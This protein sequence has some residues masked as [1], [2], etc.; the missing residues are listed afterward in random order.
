MANTA[1]HLFALA[2]LI[3]ETCLVFVVAIV[4]TRAIGGRRREAVQLAITALAPLVVWR[5]YLGF[6]LYPGSGVRAFW[7]DPEAVGRPFGG[8]ARLWTDLARGTYMPAFT[9]LAGAA[10]CYSVVLIGAL[11]LAGTAVVTYPNAAAIAAFVYALIAIS[12]TYG[13]VW[14]HVGNAQRAS[15]ELFVI[16]AI[17]Y[18]TTPADARW[19]RLAFGAFWISTAVYAWFLA[20][21]ADSIRRAMLPAIS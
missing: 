18:V 8:I 5:I 10:M 17:V 7:F 13:N 1:A 12:F 6:V 3:R 2:L 20:Y 15:Y 21:D 11:A 9:D 14:I 19:L 4:A 16:M